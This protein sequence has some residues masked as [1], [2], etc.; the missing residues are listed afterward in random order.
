MRTKK[1]P[2]LGGFVLLDKPVSSPSGPP[3][4]ESPADNDEEHDDKKDEQGTGTAHGCAAS[5]CVN[6]FNWPDCIA[7]AADVS[8][9]G[10]AH[11]GRLCGKCTNGAVNGGAT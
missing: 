10:V 1:P 6:A 11:R 3:N 5:V 2:A 9:I 7:G 4:A 8:S